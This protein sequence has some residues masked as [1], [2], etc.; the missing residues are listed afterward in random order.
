MRVVCSIFYMTRVSSWK[1]RG[2]KKT[3]S[4]VKFDEYEG[5]PRFTAL[6]LVS[7]TYNSSSI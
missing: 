3:L 7:C 2:E 4:Q 1:K 5:F 6:L